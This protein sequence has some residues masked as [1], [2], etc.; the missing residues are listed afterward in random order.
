MSRI[1]PLFVPHEGCPGQCVFCD[2]KS[3][4]Q[5]K[6]FS[7][8]E[9]ERTLEEYFH[10]PLHHGAQIAFFGGSFTAIPRE[11]MIALLE[12]AERFVQQGKASSL[13]C[14]TRPD[15]VDAS[16]LRILSRYSLT[17]VELGLQSMSDRVL[18]ACRRGHDSRCAQEAAQRV[19]DAGFRLTGQMMLGLP[20]SSLAEEEETAHA[21][22]RMG[23]ESARVYPTVVFSHTPLGEMTLRGDYS[24]L[25]PREA[26]E[27]G[28]AV[29]RIFLSRG[30]KLLRVGLCDNA[31]LHSD[32][33][34]GGANL[35]SYGEQV[36]AHLFYKA[37]RRELLPQREELS[38]KPLRLF[39][40]PSQL[41]Q[42]C[43]YQ[44]QTKQWIL[45]CFTPSSL[46][47]IPDPAL[48]P[49][50]LSYEIGEPPHRKKGFLDVLKNS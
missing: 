47:L 1:F 41:S 11:R 38:K 25:S 44:K 24:P 23:A 48:L 30:V 33:V 49:F 14:S 43:G 6:P 2:Q 17:H 3:I 4:T 18:C 5:A 27:R 31:T 40:P 9:A 15:A 50:T 45:D 19:L 29:C 35:P 28:S 32:A 34:L 8:E 36:Y 21:I 13:R 37:L 42:L 12:I 26:V 46:H 39:V 20:L 7:V 10:D 16:T 22:C